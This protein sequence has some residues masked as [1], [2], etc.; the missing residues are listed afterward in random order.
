MNLRVFFFACVLPLTAIGCCAQSQP[1]F[2][3]VSI[4][5]NVHGGDA[6]VDIT[7]GRVTMN[8]ATLRTLIR[9]GYNI[10]NFQFAGGPGWLD[11]DA[12]DVSAVI[13]GHAEVSEA[14]YRALIR[15]LLA[16][17]FQLKVHW[18]TRQGDVYALVVAKN[19]PTLKP[20]ANS[21]REPGLNIDRSPHLGRMTGVNA[22]IAYMC[23]S[24]G[25][26]LSHP[27]I[28]KTGLQG[29]YDWTLVWDPDPGPDSTQPSL[30]AAVQEQLGLKLDSEKGPVQTLVIEG[31]ARPSEN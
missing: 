23:A 26:Q 5:R 1:S 8:N 20:A 29:T 9:N 11:T 16:D 2:E 7:P 30:F 25:N 15:T 24:L 31:V 21:F 13:A 18:E 6:R 28:D 19:G 12:Y 22:P 3:A 10:Q 17:R 14:E 4:H 27:V